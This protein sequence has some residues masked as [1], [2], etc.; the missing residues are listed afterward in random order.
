MRRLR[1]VGIAFSIP[2]A[3]FLFSCSRS[4]EATLAKHVKRGDE[5]VREEKFKEAVIEYK[6]AV[7][8]VP[9]DSGAHWKLAKAAIEAK[10]VQTAFAEL[11][12]TV[13]LDPNNYEALGKLG[14]IYVMV[15]KIEEARKIADNLVKVHPADPQGYILQAGIAVLRGKMDEAI[16]KLKKA[17]ELDPKR[18]RTMLSI[19]NLEFLTHDRKSAREWYDKA[20]SVDP[21]SVEVHVARGNYFFATGEGEEGE[22]EYRKAIELSKGKENL[23][24]ALAEKYQ[25]QG[26]IEESEKELVAIIKDYNSQ[27]ARKVMAENK[28]DQG[29]VGEAKPIVD[30]ILK[31]NGKDLD[32]LYL[33]GRIAQAER[34]FDDAKALFVDVV[35]QDAGMARARLYNGLT[36]IQQGRLDVGRKEIAEAVRLDPSNARAQLIFGEISL[37]SGSPAEAEKAALEV[38]RR[39]PSSGQAAV[40]LADSYLARKEWKKAEQIYQA[41]IQQVPNSGVGYMK[42]GLSRKLQGKPG[43]AAGFF[44]KA[45][46]KNPKDLL[47]MNEYVF[48]LASAKDREKAK[49]VLEEAVRNDPKNGLVWELAGRFSAATGT[50]AEAEAAFLKAIELA[51]DI[52]SPYFQLGLIYTTQ[53]KFPEA[54]VRLRKVLEKDDKNVGAHALLGMVLNSQGEI[55]ASNK[56]Y[57]RVLDL[58]PKNA[59]AANNLA[60]NL[61][62][63]GGNLDEAL[64]FAQTARE[65]SPEDPNVSDTLGWVYYKKG[66]LEPAYPLIAEAA[67][68][69]KE[70]PVIRYHHGMVLAKKGKSK[71]AAEELKAAL[72][73]DSE[74]PGAPEARKTLD[75]MKSS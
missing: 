45:M 10:D 27:R 34:R 2:L 56:E 63:G 26:R 39:N 29:N 1:L 59:L 24:I 51:P 41:M 43:E 16:G 14:E 17:S 32:G 60:S 37:R 5:Y 23:R 40:L 20:L 68:K 22:K 21:G 65:A 62:D 46:E 6:N 49:K 44:A 74:F 47:V 3:M 66:L 52:I 42:M 13:E 73:L 15:G 25:Q 61:A 57:R 71:E 28:L 33:K 7:K 35:R 38:L 11:Q 50:P 8:A 36:D 53:K 55:D 58:S 30:A 18:S 12:E 64:K 69:A 4:P 67:G 9:K 54:E 19:A 75:M 72:A 48:A 31:E 70:N